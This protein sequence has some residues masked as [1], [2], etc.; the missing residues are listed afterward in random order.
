MKEKIFLTIFTFNGKVYNLQSHKL[1]HV[2]DILNFFGSNKSVGI[3][4]YNGSILNIQEKKATSLKNE[5]K[6]EVLTIVGGG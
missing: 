5:D 2:Q 6:I 3:S 4:E 1:F